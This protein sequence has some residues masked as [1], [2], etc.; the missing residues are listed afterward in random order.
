MEFNVI[1]NSLVYLNN[2]GI[3]NVQSFKEYNINKKILLLGNAITIDDFVD[4]SIRSDSKII[5][6][7]NCKNDYINLVDVDIGIRLEIKD[8]KY[9]KNKRIY[10]R[11]GDI[12]LSDKYIDDIKIY[13]NSM[14]IAI[15]K[16]GEVKISIVYSLYY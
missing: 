1:N 2:I 13:I 7:S 9:I 15:E 16:N 8:Y 14:V 10:L 12:L 4:I 3:R 6:H 5:S 11:R